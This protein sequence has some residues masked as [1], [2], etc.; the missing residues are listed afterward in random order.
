M[1]AHGVIAID[2]DLKEALLK[3]SYVEEL[4]EIYYHTLVINNGNEP[5][6]VSDSE[7]QN[8]NILKKLNY[9]IH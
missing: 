6:Y 8:G 9:W 1:Q 3:A 5:P 2:K 7:L 4:A